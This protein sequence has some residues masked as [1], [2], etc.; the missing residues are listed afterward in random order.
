MENFYLFGQ[1]MI[2]NI[3]QSDSTIANQLDSLKNLIA[4]NNHQITDLNN[5]LSI[6]PWLPLIGAI[7]AGVLLWIGQFLDRRARH[8]YEKKNSSRILFA[9]CELLVSQLENAFN[10][11]AT[12]GAL[13][14]FWYNCSYRQHRNKESEYKELFYNKSIQYSDESIECRKKIGELLASLHSKVSMLSIM[15]NKNIE[16]HCISHLI[17]LTPYPSPVKN[18][19]KNDDEAMEIFKQSK[20]Q[21]LKEHIELLTPIKKLIISL[22][23]HIK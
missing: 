22:R 20:E 13:L 19:A 1:K 21:L 16:L 5:N 18:D 7:T 8:S 15:L 17:T 6:T 2:D 3:N 10:E 4:I 12:I 23:L 11:V 9:D 14:E